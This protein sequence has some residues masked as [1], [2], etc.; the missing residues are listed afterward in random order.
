MR[1]WM[2][3]RAQ[4]P[5]LLGVIAQDYRIVAP[6]SLGPLFEFRPLVDVAK[7]C[8][9]YPTTM[10][11]PSRAFIPDGEVLYR[12]DPADP[13]SGRAVEPE[14]PMALFGVHTCDLEG[15]SILD[16]IYLSPPID[17]TY[18]NRRRN[19]LIVG[20][21]C[22]RPCQTESFCADKRTYSSERTFDLLLIPVDHE[23]FMVRS[24][25]GLGMAVAERSAVMAPATYRDQVELEEFRGT[26]RARFH[27]KFALDEQALSPRVRASWDDLLWGAR[28]RLCLDCGACNVV[29][30]T[31]H[32]FT[33]GD[34]LPVAEGGL[35]ERCRYW[36]GCQLET[37]ARVAGGENFRSKKANRL[38]H[39]IFK[40][41]VYGFD[42]FGRS[43]CV[44]CG[45]CGH[46]C[47]AGIKL[48]DIYRQLSE[49]TVHV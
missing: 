3:A 10:L 16:E 13:A 4:L 20:I 2:L 1:E 17:R 7:L 31:C 21:E 6:Q 14:P 23:R 9:D 22:E 11:P 36:T 42:R 34:R 27:R 35:G 49:E 41:E 8:L 28:S 39:R 40:K 38:R 47:P 46:F 48:V 12:F 30:P 5:R 19:A 33:I 32:C 18:A 37:F 44:G 25:T 15:I 29:C 24:R 43:G 45:R 26:Q